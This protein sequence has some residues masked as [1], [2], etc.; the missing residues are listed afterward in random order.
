MKFVRPEEIPMPNWL[1]LLADAEAV[2]QGLN[3]PYRTVDL[4]T[5]DIGFSAARTL[6]IRNLAPRPGDLIAKSPPVQN[7]HGFPGA[8]GEYPFPRMREGKR[9]FVHTLNGSGLAIGRT[10]LAILE[11]YQRNETAPWSSPRSL[12][13][14]PGWCR[15]E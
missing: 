8:A 1:P 3:L 14:L 7:F 13:P 12:R 4:C 9:Q 15:R 5:G 6:D 10:W 11:N 2:L